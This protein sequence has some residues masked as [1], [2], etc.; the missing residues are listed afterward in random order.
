MQTKFLLPNK[1]KKVGIGLMFLSI[2]LLILANFEMLNFLEDMSIPAVYNS[3]VALFESRNS[4]FFRM[5]QDDFHFELIST[6]FIIGGLM[7]SFSKLKNEDEFISKLRLES[8]LWAV[9]I[10]FILLVIAT[11][12]IYGGDYFNVLVLNMFTILVLFIIRFHFVLYIKEKAK[13]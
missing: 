4:G 1:Y 6:L 3:D 2:T 7:V 8:L 9:L 5:I 11:L 13:S 12:T 10:H